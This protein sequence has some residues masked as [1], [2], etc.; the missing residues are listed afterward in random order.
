MTTKQIQAIGNF[1]TYYQTDLNYIRKFQDFKNGKITAENYIKK[2]VGSFYSFLIEF[3]VVRNFP[4][5]T[6]D[7]L[8]AETSIWI[9]TENSDDVDL[10]AE[11]L[12]NSGLTRGN[13]MA[14]M[15]SKILFL[16][17]PWKII[18]M[19]SLARKTLN[20]KQ[21]KYAIYNQNLIAFRKQNETIFESSINYT[22]P[23]TNIIHDEFE[24]LENLNLICKNRIVDKLLWTNGK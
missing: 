22:N 7:K 1:L 19:D 21:N 15:A 20:Q 24:D 3:R 11:K 12:A 8:L 10:F 6:V 14:S 2:D 4:S 18:P 5:G 23:L 9:K 16:N 13:V 17:N